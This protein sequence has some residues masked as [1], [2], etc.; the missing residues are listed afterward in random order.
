M[1]WRAPPQRS[2]CNL[3]FG[4][5]LRL[6]FLRLGL[7]PWGRF[8]S[9]LGVMSSARFDMG[10]ARGVLNRRLRRGVRPYR[11]NAFDSV[12]GGTS[13]EEELRT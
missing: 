5:A 6:R 9:R 7:R 2:G 8:A 1:N 3:L 4:R 12:A 10:S 11:N 13:R